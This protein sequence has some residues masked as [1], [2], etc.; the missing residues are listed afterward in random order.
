MGTRGTLGEGVLLGVVVDMVL[1]SGRAM[2]LDG[3]F[4][5]C[6]GTCD[7]DCTNDEKEEAAV[8]A[9]ADFR[10]VVMFTTIAMN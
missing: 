7:C 4:H 2:E 6:T 9:D 3:L 10:L 8:D 5:A 1:G